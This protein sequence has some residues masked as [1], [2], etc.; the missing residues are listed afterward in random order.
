M[1][2]L[3]LKLFCELIKCGHGVPHFVISSVGFGNPFVKFHFDPSTKR[4][5]GLVQEALQKVPSSDRAS[6]P[7]IARD[8]PKRHFI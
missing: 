8:I 5:F 7:F 1:R 6:E 3:E 2:K 4:F